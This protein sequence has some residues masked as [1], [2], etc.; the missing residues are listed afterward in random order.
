[1]SRQT[2]VETFRAAKAAGSSLSNSTTP[3]SLLATAD[4]ITLPPNFLEPGRQLR[5]TATGRISNI[6]T[7]PG[8]LTLDVRLGSVVAFNGGAMQL[9]TTAHTTLPWWLD[10]LLTV[11][12]EGNSTS[13]NLIGLAKMTSQAVSVSGA[14]PTTGHSI[15]V[16]P[17]STPT[18]GTG[19]DSTVAQTLDLFATFS[20]A[21]SGNLIALEQL[22]VESL[23]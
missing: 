6:V 2:W 11:R 8:T 20:I 22:V 16:A 15:L 23:N 18:V 9:S 19:Y 7:T 17:N 13:G 12:A 1:M 21:N 3:T 14:D 10:I 5:I 4:K